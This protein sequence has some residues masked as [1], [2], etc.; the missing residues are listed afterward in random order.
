MLN[1]WKLWKGQIFAKVEINFVQTSEKSNLLGR[2]YWIRGWIMSTTLSGS[3]PIH[4]GFISE[5]LSRNSQIHRK[6]NSTK[7]ILSIFSILA[8]FCSSVWF[9][10]HSSFWLNSNICPQSSSI[11]DV[12]KRQKTCKEATCRPSW[13][14]NTMALFMYEW[15]LSQTHLHALYST[16][17]WVLFGFLALYFHLSVTQ[18]T[19]NP[20]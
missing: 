17:S 8:G 18:L 6:E 20:G 11:F 7:W 15:F 12:L 10:L 2:T 1:L 5:Y 19:T 14:W 9:C 4:L 16:Y 3:A 13:Q